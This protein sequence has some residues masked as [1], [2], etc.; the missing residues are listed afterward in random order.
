LNAESTLTVFLGRIAGV[1][2]LAVGRA[3]LGALIASAASLALSSVMARTPERYA[4]P[5]LSVQ[6]GALSFTAPA[7]SPSVLTQTLALTNTTASTIMT[8]TVSVDGAAQV[9]PTVSPISGTNN[10]TV[11][12]QLNTGAFSLTGVY[13]GALVITAE[14]TTTVGSPLT[15]PITLRVMSQTFL[16]NIQR[17]SR[18]RKRRPTKRACST[19][20]MRA[21]AWIAGRSTGKRLSEPLASLC[22]TTRSTTRIAL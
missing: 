4:D 13:S 9:Q 6:P 10:G 22:G 14:P 19:R 21:R 20:W 17:S 8:W 3:A 18:R 2:R 7:T 12:V 11:T 15:I 16:P 5:A 1:G